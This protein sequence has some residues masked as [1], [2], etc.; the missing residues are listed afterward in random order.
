MF[1]CAI[2]NLI[3][4]SDSFGPALNKHL[5]VILP[6]MRK[7]PDLVKGNAKVT[8]LI[9]ELRNNGGTEADKILKIVWKA[10]SL[11]L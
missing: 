9:D 6:L 5:P 7:R 10:P 1:Y 2:D 8:H 3:E 11:K 4:A